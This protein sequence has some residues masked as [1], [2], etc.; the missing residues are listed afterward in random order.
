MKQILSFLCLAILLAA[1]NNDQNK[2]AEPAADAAA[3]AAEVKLPYSLSMPY[4]NW[5]IGSNENVA[6][7]MNGLKAFVDND[8]TALAATLGDSIVLDF[9]QLQTKMSK[10]SAMK[11]FT[12]ARAAY[13]DITIAMDDYVSVISAD[14]KHEWVTLWYKQTWTDP[15][16]VKDSMNVINDIK[17]SNGKMVALHEKSSRFQKK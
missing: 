15:K 12:N 6:A 4:N 10:D 16:G 3:P 17:L 1:C 5:S 9:D 13:K 11:F 7:A 14:K 8:F 2:T